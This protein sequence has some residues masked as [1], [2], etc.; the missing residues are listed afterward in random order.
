VKYGKVKKLEGKIVKEINEKICEKV[1]IEK[2][3][4]RREWRDE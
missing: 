4:E 3:N 2:M 1:K